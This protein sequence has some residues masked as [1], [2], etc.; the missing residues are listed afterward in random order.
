MENEG[1]KKKV[2]L[3]SGSGQFPLIWVREAKRLGYHVTAIAHIGETV[4]ELEAVADSVVWV[5]LGELGKIIRTFKDADI[6]QVAFAG[7]IRKARMFKDA[8]PDLRATGLLARIGIPKDDTILRALSDELASDGIQVIESTSFLSTL[9]TPPGQLTSRAV[10][11][12]EEKDISFGWKTLKELS[13]IEIGQC[14]IVK[15]GTILAVEAMEGTDGAIRRGGG[16]AQKGAV[17][18]KASKP[19]QDLRF[20]LPAVGADT[21][22]AMSEVHATVLALEA[23]KS[24]ILEKDKTLKMAESAGISV[25]G[26]H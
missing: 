5:R 22:S 24:I 26:C 8:K 3:I 11:P 7:G 13:R 17:V 4:Q 1:Q 18:V 10:N 14:I 23:G 12:E 15:R 20:D 6:S 16:L 21:I 2:G 19:H 25:I 9:L